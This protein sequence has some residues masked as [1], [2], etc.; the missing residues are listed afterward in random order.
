MRRW[1]EALACW[2]PRSLRARL[3]WCIA[4]AVVMLL[5][6]TDW[7]AGPLQ[8]SF[9]AGVS[10]LLGAAAILVLA[11]WAVARLI[12]PVR[13]MARVIE[14]Q[15]VED[16][17]GPL[18]ERGPLEARA[19]AQAFN[20][21]RERIADLLDDQKRMLAAISHDLRT[22]ATRL[23]LRV[24]FVREDADLQRLM[25][26]DLDEMDAMLTEAMTFLADDVRG[27]PRKLVDLSA[28]LQAVCDDYADVG[29]PVAFAEPPPLRFRSVPTLFAAAGQELS[30]AS[31]RRVR[32]QCRPNAL[33]RAVNNLIDNALKYG[34]RADVQLDADA[35]HVRIGVLDRGPGIPL[36]EIDKVLL[37][38]Y[39]I[40][41]SRQRSTGG[42]GLGL[43]IVKTVADAHR[44]RI[45]L[46]NRAE[47]GLLAT[48]ELP[49]EV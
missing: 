41:S 47:G 2:A 21:Q 11:D 44:G 22:P 27:E 8:R 49:R 20:R 40:E 37:P 18:P 31:E 23:R 33:R 12:E 3:L 29:Q 36:A 24:E 28:L 45:E 39:R 15:G 5:V 4:S 16:P 35:K 6:L 9:G 43:A 42:M 25:L 48:L 14:Q 38:F 13:E 10:L 32:L 7:L 34:F 1:P 46:C 30:F 26:R 17:G 19:M